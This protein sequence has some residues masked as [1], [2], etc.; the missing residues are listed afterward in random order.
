MGKA[1][2]RVV[3][4]LF[5]LLPPSE[6][7]AEG[8]S[9][10]AKWR[11][12]SGVFGKQLAAQRKALVDQLTKSK[13]GDE[14]LLGVSKALLARAKD[15]NS[16]LRG[17]PTLAACERYTGV[18]WDHLDLASLTSSQRT[19]A[20]NSIVVI[21]GL[22]GAVSAADP[23]PD[24]RLKMGARFAPFGLLSKWWHDSLSET[25]N[26]A[27]KGSVVIDLLPQEHRAAF[28]L[29]TNIVAKHIVV[30][31]NE[32]SGKAGGHDA[33]AAKGRLARHLV[34]TC[35]SSSQ[36][37]KSLQSFRDPRF[38]VTSDLA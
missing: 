13:G 36:V 25:L 14:K 31:I 5:I 16:S 12:S 1:D 15:A 4:S 21:S 37:A 6:G 23:V 7:K 17:A 22:L 29:D 26:T 9:A 8:G 28:T 24:Y 30:A 33:K 19:R 18:V 34:Q 11:E 32:K 3:A 20:L 35:T 10:T 27:F 2:F 38:V